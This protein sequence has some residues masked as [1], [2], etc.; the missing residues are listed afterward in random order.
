VSEVTSIEVPSPE[1]CDQLA[2]VTE[3]GLELEAR[4]L[5][6]ARDAGEAWRAFDADTA[7][8]D[9]EALERAAIQAGLGVLHALIERMTVALGS[10]GS[11]NDER[12]AA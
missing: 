10:L 3:D 2:I 5:A 7:D 11:P 6:F 12:E 4:V 9:G 8:L 1:V